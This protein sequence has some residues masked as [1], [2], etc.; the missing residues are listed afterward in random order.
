MQDI[1]CEENNVHIIIVFLFFR[2]RIIEYE[3]YFIFQ[4]SGFGK[5]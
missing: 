5:F 4:I 2:V 1:F 3:L